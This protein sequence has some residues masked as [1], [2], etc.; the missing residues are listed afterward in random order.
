VVGTG[1]SRAH[2]TRCTLQYTV[3]TQED[4]LSQALHR[5]DG[6]E[7]LDDTGTWCCEDRIYIND[8]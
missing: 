1:E 2:S 8:L 6:S 3:S 5:A 7:Y 4:P